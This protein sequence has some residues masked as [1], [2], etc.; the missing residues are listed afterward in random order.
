MVDA[1]TDTLKIIDF[2]LSKHLESAVTLGVGTPD[3][4]APEMLGY[5]GGRHQAQIHAQGGP[6]SKL[7]DAR[8]V[9]SP[10]PPFPHPRRLHR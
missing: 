6:N 8:S 5:G 10:P 3:Y 4:M 1:K 2:G 9:L 7:Y